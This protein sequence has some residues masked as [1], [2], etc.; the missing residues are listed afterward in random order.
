M[1]ANKNSKIA[2]KKNVKN[3]KKIVKKVNKNIVSKY[4]TDVVKD[5]IKSELICTIKKNKYF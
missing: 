1:L 5:I 3:L 2:R 4:I